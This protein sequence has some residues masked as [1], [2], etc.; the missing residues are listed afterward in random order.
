[1]PKGQALSTPTTSSSGSDRPNEAAVA[2]DPPSSSGSKRRIGDFELLTKLGQGAMGAVYLA[3]QVQLDR[4]VA[5]KILPP[6][7]AQD[8]E[9]LERF[10]REA[11]AAARLNNPHIVMAYDVG[12]AG[13]YHYIAMEY[14][15]GRDLEQGLQAQPK[16]RYT[17]SEVLN[18]AR[19]MAHALEAASAAGITH[20]DMKPANILKHSDGTYKLTDL[21]LAARKVEDNKVTQ[22]GSAVGTPFYIS[23]EQARGEQNVDVR[24][25]IYS[26]GATLFHLV[27][28]RL[29]F[30]GDNSVVVMTRH[31]TEQVQPPDEVEPGVSKG[32]S[33]LI[34]KMMA[35]NPKDRHQS[36]RELLDD[37]DLIERGE[38]PLL[39]RAR[40]K[41]KAPGVLLPVE[42]PSAAA[43]R[44]KEKNKEKDKRE[45]SRDQPQGSRLKPRASL[46][47]SIHP[48]LS[49]GPGGKKPLERTG[50][51]GSVGLSSGART[52]I[53]F[54]VLF[55]VAVLA[56]VVISRVIL[57]MF[58]DAPA[59]APAPPP[60][61]ATPPVKTEA[62]TND[63]EKKTAAPLPAPAAVPPPAPPP[64][65][66]TVTEAPPEKLPPPPAPI[67]APLAGKSVYKADFTAGQPENWN[68]DLVDAPAPFEGSSK[69]G[70]L[71]VTPAHWYWGLGGANNKLNLQLTAP[72]R[73]CLRLCY[74][75]QKKENEILITLRF[76]QG[77]S[78]S[79]FKLRGLVVGRWDEKSVE[80]R[81]FPIENQIDRE[82]HRLLAPSFDKKIL[83]IELVTGQKRA[84]PGLFL[85]Y[86]EFFERDP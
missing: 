67:P 71:K 70:A 64:V 82:G 35:K 50:P 16:G 57:P 46:P 61:A 74:F 75:L 84:T 83:S 31:L 45:E 47:G 55:I 14:V 12:V 51:L 42:S 9:F 80:I 86:L 1:M 7:L 58:Q 6:D 76:G 21:G 73:T 85:R 37:L 24:S 36:A 3:R 22:T 32:L 25:D 43:A 41:P 26:L 18:I 40:A 23:P 68:L 2:H 4:N 15:D 34:V 63:A 54:G 62:P 52:A 8:Q 17:E 53:G 49:R 33:R 66:K 38:V 29:P 19:Q 72:Q 65:Q 60:R 10:R 48:K 44:E 81:E 56:G 30:P 13:G 39:K 59:P 28:G 5:L 77:I 20:R 78:V 79:T 11:R 27:T 69:C